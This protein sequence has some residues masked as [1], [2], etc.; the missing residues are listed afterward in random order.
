M[1]CPEEA[2]DCRQDANVQ[3]AQGNRG[4]EVRI[5]DVA[6]VIGNACVAESIHLPTAA[7]SLSQLIKE[8]RSTDADLIDAVR[9]DADKEL[10]V[11]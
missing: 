10:A 6:D 5:A 4:I 8:P 11:Q 2:Q 9:V 7:T 3:D 1:S